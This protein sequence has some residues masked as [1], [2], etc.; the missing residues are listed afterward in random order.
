MMRSLGGPSEDQRHTRTI[1][2]ETASCFAVTARTQTKTGWVQ[3]TSYG[4]MGGTDGIKGRGSRP[5]LKK[6]P[7]WKPK[8]HTATP[9]VA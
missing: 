6:R 5:K 7:R 3:I 4:A 1:G 9:G 8:L 2:T